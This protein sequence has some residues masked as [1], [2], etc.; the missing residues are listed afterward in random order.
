M[1]KK[2]KDKD[3]FAFDRMIEKE[4]KRMLHMI[5]NSFFWKL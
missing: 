2:D 4:K 1:N 3:S 5:K